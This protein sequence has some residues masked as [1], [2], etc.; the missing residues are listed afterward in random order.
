MDTHSVDVVVIGAGQAGLS[1][2][3]HL[4]R[5]GFAP[6]TGFV[7][8]DADDG[9]G[10][11]WRHRWPTLT[12][13][14]V[15]GF[16]DLP[17]MPFPDAAPDRSAAEVV[18]G[19]FAAYE[20][21]FALPVR[22]PVRVEAV[23][24]LPDGRLEVRTDGG[25][26]VARALI[27]ATGTWSRPFWPHYP[28]RSE[29]RGR[30]LHTA[31]YRGPDEFAGRRVVVVGAG[32]S[33][34][35]L[36]GEISA[37][38]AGTTWVSRRPPDFREIEFT[39]EHGR[40]AVALVEA[41]V[42]EGRPPSSVVG[43][44]GLPVTAE[45]RRLREQGVLDRLPMFDRITPDGVA[46]DDGRFVPADTILWCTGFRAALDHLAPLKLRGPGGGIVMD[47]TRVV[48]DDRIHLIGYGPSASTI[49]ANRAGRAAVR[50][51]RALRA[52]D[53]VLHRG[54]SI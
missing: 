40:A 44:T 34:V 11:A 35:Q 27:N 52:R 49:G 38:A 1:A 51:I 14:R 17:A 22:R 36:L 21:E 37:V 26:W 50:E 47:G 16:H 41:R 43:V 2:A 19:Y 54:A 9:P 33:A 30:Q 3:Y 45:V 32:T 18:T 39:S 24:S 42:R 23:H 28:G 4:H 12:V 10:G 53:T 31:D 25:I 5:T 15:H 8:L 46:W 48:A 13:D 20:H 29:F 6:G 7:V